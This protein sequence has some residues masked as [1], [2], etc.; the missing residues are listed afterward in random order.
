MRRTALLIL[1]ALG[2]GLALGAGAGGL[3]FSYLPPRW[4]RQVDITEMELACIEGRFR[5]QEPATLVKGRILATEIEAKPLPTHVHL[6]VQVKLEGTERGTLQRSELDGA[7][8][9]LVH[10]WRDKLVRKPIPRPPVCPVTI[11]LIHNSKTIYRLIH[12]RLGRRGYVNPK[13]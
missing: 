2:V 8:T 6:K 9:V 12:N 5:A 13:I 7:C 4:S 10:Y 3:K 1:L 11:D